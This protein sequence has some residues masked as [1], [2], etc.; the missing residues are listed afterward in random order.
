[1][2]QQR[3]SVWVESAACRNCK[4]LIICNLGVPSNGLSEDDLQS[5][6]RSYNC[7]HVKICRQ[8]DASGV[9]A[10]ATSLLSCHAAR[11]FDDS[12]SLL[13]GICRRIGCALQVIIA[14]QA[15]F[16]LVRLPG[17]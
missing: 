3:C 11:S 5:V 8:R 7:I 9:F 14:G 4:K 13:L 10:L 17:M 1:M 6:F 16:C 12:A 2:K 15:S